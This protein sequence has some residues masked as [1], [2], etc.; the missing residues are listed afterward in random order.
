MKT[1][2]IVAMIAGLFIFAGI[3]VVKAVSNDAPIQQ[4]KVSTCSS[5]G[6][7]C[8]AENNCGLATCGAVSKTGSCGCG[9]K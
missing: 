7:S 2:L 8:T 3:A 9:K 5:C 1:W 6:N 4:E